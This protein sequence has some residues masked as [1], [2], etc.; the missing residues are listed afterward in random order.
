M[1]AAPKKSITVFLPDGTTKVLE[2]VSEIY[3]APFRFWEEVADALKLPGCSEGVSCCGELGPAEF[4][5][6]PKQYVW[7]HR[8][9]L[10]RP[11]QVGPNHH[12]YSE[13]SPTLD[14]TAFEDWSESLPN[15]QRT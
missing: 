1:I 10:Y 14:V 3:K 8:I 9:T 13:P 5:E 15:V 12:V 4:G 6:H 2:G 7:H 11:E